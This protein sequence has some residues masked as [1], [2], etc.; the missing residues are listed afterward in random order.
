MKKRIIFASCLGFMM[1]L[2]LFIGRYGSSMQEVLH[3]LVFQGNDMI[4]RLLWNIRIPRILLVSI[5]G[6]ALALSGVVYQTIFKNPLASGDVIGASSGC[7]LGAVLAILCF[8]STWVVEG[9]AFLGG[10]L[11]VGCTMFLAHRVKGNR[12][13]NLVI[14]GLILQA[15]TTSLMM[16][17]KICADPQQQLASIEYWLMGGFSD[18]GWKQVGITFVIVLICGLLLYSLRWQIQMLGFGEEAETLGVAAKKI[19]LSALLLSTL[20]ISCVISV[21]GIVSWVGL[22]VPHIIRLLTKQPISKNMGLTF[23]CGSLFLLICDNLARSLFVVELPISI[24]TS[25]FGAVC[26]IVLFVKGRLP[27]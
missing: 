20:L 17:L 24:L 18:S 23:L 10:L 4:I 5:C 12:I 27:L 3:A 2:S 9:F 26:L 13:L 25:L 8:Q 16:V 6:G 15:L 11:S 21:A 22:L 19:R 1:L 7:S 14:A